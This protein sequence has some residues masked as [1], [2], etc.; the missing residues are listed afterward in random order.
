MKPVHKI[1]IK[2]LLGEDPQYKGEWLKKKNDLSA[3]TDTKIRRV[4]MGLFREMEKK[5]DALKKS[6]AGSSIRI[7]KDAANADD[8]FNTKAQIKELE[9]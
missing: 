8:G 9:A 2:N 3:I 4:K 7:Y 1:E 6:F 5:I